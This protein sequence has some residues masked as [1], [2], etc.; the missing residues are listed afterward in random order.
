MERGQPL[1]AFD[2]SRISGPEIHVRNARPGEVFE[3]LNGNTYELTSEHLVVADREKTVALAGIMGGAE[4]EVTED[5]TDLLIECAY[6]NPTRIRKGSKS[7]G[8][9]TDSSYRFERGVD[10]HGLGGVID[11]CVGLILET[12]GGEVTSDRLDILN[13]DYLPEP[14][15]ISLRTSRACEKIGVHISDSEQ[16]EILRKLGCEVDEKDPEV[17]QVT[18]PGFRP[19]LSREIDL[20]EELAR[21]FGYESIQSAPPGMPT[22]PSE[23]L[24]NLAVEKS[25]RKFLVDRGWIETKSFSFVPADF[26]EKLRLGEGHPLRHSVRIENPIGGDMA[27]LRTTMILNLLET[28]QRNSYR[29]ERSLRVFESG[30]VYLRDLKDLLD[31]ERE[32]IGLAWMGSAPSH[33]AVPDRGYDFFDAKGTVESLLLDLGVKNFRIEPMACEYFHP[34]QCG[35]WFVGERIIGVVGRLHPEIAKNFELP[36]DPILAELDVEGIRLE[37]DRSFVQVRR[38]SPFPPIRRDLSLTVGVGT[39]AREL[40]SLIESRETPFLEKIELFDRYVGDQVG[41]GNQSL[42]FRLT[43]RAADRTLTEQEIAPIHLNLLKTLNE[44]LGATQRGMN[45]THE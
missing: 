31:C 2:L 32:A 43:Y 13:P 20:I 16:S 34:S 35:R 21:H 33:W 5:T 15:T 6:F 36:S 11:R 4:S 37:R 39:E 40:V 24:P 1:H 28:L 8:L 12:A 41:P 23:T 9:S 25:I 27:Q 14:Q 17:F 38:P 18:P 7:L 22:A 19:D 45:P 29:G 30:K 44:K 3:A 26:A 42:G 10:P